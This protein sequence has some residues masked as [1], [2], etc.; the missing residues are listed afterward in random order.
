MAKLFLRT[1][2]CQMN[3][4]DSDSIADV[5]R[6]PKAWRPRRG[7]GRRRDRLQHLLGAREGAGEGVRRPRA[8]EAPEARN[9]D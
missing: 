5:L 1:F 9:P 4:Y 3:E 7:R 6:A 8:R 2:G